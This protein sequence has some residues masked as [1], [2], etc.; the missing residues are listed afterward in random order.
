[1]TNEDRNQ[2]RTVAS[3]P[4]GS[5]WGYWPFVSPVV[6]VVIGIAVQTALLAYFKTHLSG[7]EVCIRHNGKV[8]VLWDNELVQEAVL[9]V[10]GSITI[11]F[12]LLAFLA[13]ESYKQTVLLKAAAKDLGIECEPQVGVANKT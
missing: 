4:L 3:R 2:I 11:T 7:F 1:M 5:V 10:S 13:R 6:F 9:V 8:D 12:V